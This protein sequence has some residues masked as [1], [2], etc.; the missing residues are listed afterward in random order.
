MIVRSPV[1]YK[2]EQ[3]GVVLVLGLIF[4]AIVSGLTISSINN[5][6]LIEEISFNTQESAYVKQGTE[7]AAARSLTNTTWVNT[8]LRIMD[9]GSTAQFPNYDITFDTNTQLTAT[10]TL[11]A[12]REVVPGYTID[13]ESDISFIRLQIDSDAELSTI[14][15]ESRMTYG[16]MR[17]G[18]GG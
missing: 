3:Q 1:I 10:S 8:A 16:Y 17:L 11:S 18:A 15:I 5:S 2:R 4:M 6:T 7:N 13:T 14:D 9:D 12:F